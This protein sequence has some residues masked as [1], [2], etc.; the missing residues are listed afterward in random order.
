M[1]HKKQTFKE[2]Y[3]E[4]LKKYDVP[5]DEKYILLDIT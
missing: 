5:F 2:E 3:I 1:H 4:M